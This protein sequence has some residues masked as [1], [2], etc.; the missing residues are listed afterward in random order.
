MSIKQKCIK[1]K[2]HLGGFTIVELLVIVITLGI[3][4]TVVISYMNPAQ[5]IAQARDTTRLNDLGTLDNALSIA[6]IGNISLGTSNTI[7]ISLPDTSS[8]CANLN[9]PTIPTGWSYACVTTANLQKTNGTGWVPV[10]ISASLPKLP[11]DPTNQLPNLYYSYV[12]SGTKYELSAAMVADSNKLGGVKDRT[13]T[14]GGA[15]SSVYEIGS[16]MALNP[17]NGV[18]IN[19]GFEYAPTFTAAQT[20]GNWINGTAAGSSTRQ[21]YAVHA[22]S[23]GGGSYAKFDSTN[24]H[25]GLNS[26]KL[27]IVPGTYIEG[28]VNAICYWCADGIKLLPN[29]TYKYS[30]WMKS[31]NVSGS[32]AHGQMVTFLFADSSGAGANVTYSGSGG[33]GT[34]GSFTLTDVI[35]ANKVWTQYTGA[36]TTSSTVAWF[37]P[38]YRVY[39]HTGAATLTG[40]FW[41]DD[42]AVY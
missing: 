32:S 18:I 14:D 42:M 22:G 11:I 3:I 12:T 41:F 27:H 16:D 33:S 13:S 8:T 23:V 25:S 7:Y 24:P 26:L 36:F 37:H 31:E 9:L 21:S 38:E 17:I 34:S 6:K 4:V 28:R 10:N 35:L 30:V 19:G 5:L 20:S 2:S 15:S 1:R 39:A 29:T 40:D